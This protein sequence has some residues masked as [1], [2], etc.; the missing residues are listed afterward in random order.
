MTAERN[1]RERQQD[2]RALKKRDRKTER[3]EKRKK[4]WKIVRQ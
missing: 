3:E 1:D 2:I 4:D